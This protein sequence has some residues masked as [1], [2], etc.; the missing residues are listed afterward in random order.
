MIR[1][2]HLL[3]AL[4]SDTGS[5][6]F[7]VKKAEFP[8]I[9]GL[10]LYFP[11]GHQTRLEKME[12]WLKSLNRNPVSWLR[13]S[14]DCWI[15]DIDGAKQHF[16][17]EVKKRHPYTSDVSWPS[18][19]FG[20]VA[21]SPELEVGEGFVPR[22]AIHLTELSVARAKNP[23]PQLSV[24]K[25]P[26][27]PWSSGSFYLVTIVALIL[28]VRIAFGQLSPWWL[29]ITLVFGL[30]ACTVIGAFQLKN[31]QR[32]SEGGFLNVMGLAFK[33]LPLIRLLVPKKDENTKH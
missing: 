25:K 31:D 29:P 14:V 17:D 5:V 24:D 9:E 27:S 12:Y 19:L 18:W 21:V 16:V 26:S 7:A 2:M 28:T 22:L 32:V 10:R 6:T 15:V 4:P 30:L 13:P 20:S 23:N 3:M 8:P 1:N 33:S 11:S